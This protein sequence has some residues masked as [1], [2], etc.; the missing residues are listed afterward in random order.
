MSAVSW[1]KCVQGVTYDE[2]DPNMYSC[3]SRPLNCFLQHVDKERVRLD[4]PP[5][6][7]AVFLCL[8]GVSRE[9]AKGRFQVNIGSLRV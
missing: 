7:A 2:A 5:R 8:W 3:V 1:G 6:V 9:R 4:P